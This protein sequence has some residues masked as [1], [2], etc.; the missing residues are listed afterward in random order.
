MKTKI[1]ARVAVGKTEIV[2]FDIGI[3]VCP[4]FSKKP[5]LV[6]LKPLWNF[7]MIESNDSG[8]F[9]ICGAN[10]GTNNKEGVHEMIMDGGTFDD[11]GYS[12][13]RLATEEEIEKYRT[14]D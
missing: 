10:C 9:H 7:P 8:E 13:I 3:C 6:G 5:F 11:E 14:E 12:S 2:E 4:S 1:E